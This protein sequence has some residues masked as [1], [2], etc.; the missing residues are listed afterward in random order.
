MGFFDFP[1]FHHGM[2]RSLTHLYGLRRF[3]FGRP[4][5]FFAS[6][7][8][9]ERRRRPQFKVKWQDVN[10]ARDVEVGENFENGGTL[11]RCDFGTLSEPILFLENSE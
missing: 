9:V 2:Y 4:P 7:Q 10:G 8:S 1:T 3:C 6:S 5:E 11:L